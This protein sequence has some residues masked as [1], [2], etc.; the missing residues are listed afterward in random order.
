MTTEQDA[1][2][3]KI[4]SLVEQFCKKILKLPRTFSSIITLSSGKFTSSRLVA[5]YLGI[6]TIFVDKRNVSP[7]SLFVDDIFDSGS[8]FEKVI[9]KTDRPSKLVFATL[10]AQRGKN[11]SLIFY[12]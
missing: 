3:N 12:I 8:A 2:W 4:E 10:F 7:N 1:S 5:D 6:E 11:I 9:S